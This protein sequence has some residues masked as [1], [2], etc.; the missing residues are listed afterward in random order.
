MVPLFVPFYKETYTRSTQYDS[1]PAET[2]RHTLL[3]YS[4]LLEVL[5]MD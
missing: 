3:D 2:G 4:L 5:R 1:F